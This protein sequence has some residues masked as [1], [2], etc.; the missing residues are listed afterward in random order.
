MLIVREQ[1]IISPEPVEKS[2]FVRLEE[3]F[4][5]PKFLWSDFKALMDMYSEPSAFEKGTEHNLIESV[6]FDSPSLKT[7]T[8]HF[9]NKIRRVKVRTRRYAPNGEWKKKSVFIEIK[10]KE[11]GVSKKERMK[12]PI[13]QAEALILGR[14]VSAT[15]RL[16]S[17]NKHTNVSE[18]CERV[19]ILNSLVRSYNLK[20]Q[21]RVVYERKAYEKDGL[22]VTIDENLNFEILRELDPGVVD[23][24]RRSDFWM[25]AQIMKNSFQRD[26]FLILEIK[27]TGQIPEWLLGFL[28]AAGINKAHFSKYCFSLT[29]S[30]VGG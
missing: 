19:A 18:L 20:P 1:Q 5:L 14:S 13:E 2:T 10:R 7:Y 26:K 3:K 27:H 24:I 4:L 29:S 28:R 22:R 9:T 17:K 16:I 8:D 25:Q 6:Y 11:E 23:A 12:L 30:M 21:A 15:E